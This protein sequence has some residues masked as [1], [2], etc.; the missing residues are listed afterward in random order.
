MKPQDL[1]KEIAGLMFLLHVRKN[2]LKSIPLE[3][4]LFEANAKGYGQFSL[5]EKKVLFTKFQQLL[6]RDIIF[7]FTLYETESNLTKQELLKY[8]DDA[9]LN[10]LL[11]YL[12]FFVN[13]KISIHLCHLKTFYRYFHKFC[14]LQI[15]LEESSAETINMVLYSKENKL[16][17]LLTLTEIHGAL[18]QPIFTWKV[19]NLFYCGPPS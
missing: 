7:L 12:F 17:L 15:M 3:E 16:Q 19:D 18:L 8:A 4:F 6:M 2:G 1:S 13:E 14:D 9:S 10:T 5:E 11:L